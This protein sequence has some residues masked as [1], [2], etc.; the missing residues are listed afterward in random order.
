[1]LSGA[2][3]VTC[4]A[5]VLTAILVVFGLA[6]SIAAVAAA[7]VE[8]ASRRARIDVEEQPVVN[9]NHAQNKES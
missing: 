6:L 1:M 7:S 2:E 8:S 9:G 3:V 5:L 4:V